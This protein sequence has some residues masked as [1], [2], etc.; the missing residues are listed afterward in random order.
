MARA[1][2]TGAYAAPVLLSASALASHVGASPPPGPSI[3]CGTTGLSFIQDA[4]LLGVF[5]SSTYNVYAQPNTTATPSLIGSFTADTEGV[6]FPSPPL[7]VTVPF[8][9][10]SVTVSVYLT[11][12]GGAP[13]GPPTASFVSTI[14]G[15]LA[16]TSG[17]TLPVTSL[18]PRLLAKVIQEQTGCPAGAT[19][20]W[21]EVVDANIVNAS[22]NAS[23][24][25]YL[26]ANNA[27]GGAYVPA[28]SVATNAQ[29][30]G[31]AILRTSVA[32]TGGAPT[33]AT[34]KAV[35]AGSLPT[36]AGA[37]T[38]AAAPTGDPATSSLFTVS[39]AGTITSQSVPKPLLIGVR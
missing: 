7:M 26:L 36:V 30:N 22:P 10:T 33:G 16:C 24:D 4:L 5:A 3:A 28:G 39:C 18:T 8:G 27:V 19:T 9:T 37:L 1:L 32:T 21:V 23:Y 29:G 14:A 2:K 31:G 35:P 38:A 13:P 12:G 20:P 11:S 6:A 34:V 15:T 25:I 17:A